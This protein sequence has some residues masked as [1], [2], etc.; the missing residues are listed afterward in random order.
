[1]FPSSKIPT[2]TNSKSPMTSKVIGVGTASSRDFLKSRQ[3]RELP[4]A[5]SS[6]EHKQQPQPSL[7]WVLVHRSARGG[8]GGFDTQEVLS[9][10]PPP[11]PD[12]QLK[13]VHSIANRVSTNQHQTAHFWAAF[14]QIS[15]GLSNASYPFSD[16]PTRLFLAELSKPVRVRT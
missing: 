11:P 6:L 4:K 12:Q 10:P 2:A 16:V 15:L 1:M 8:R 9:T 7:V 14:D 5:S 13:L 3:H